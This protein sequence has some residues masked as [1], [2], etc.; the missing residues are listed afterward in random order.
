MNFKV[1]IAPACFLLL[2]AC[3]TYPAQTTSN[4]DVEAAVTEEVAS[5]D[6]AAVVDQ[7]TEDSLNTVVCRRT[8]ITGSRFKR[9]VCFTRRQWRDMQT[10]TQRDIES[11]QR[12]NTQ[13]NNPQGG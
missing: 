8:I 3:T 12:M 11:N 5:A 9:K 4:T 2:G 7:K 13:T 1:L 10:Q 6:A